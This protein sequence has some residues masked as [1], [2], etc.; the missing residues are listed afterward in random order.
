MVIIF[1]IFIIYGSGQN[2]TNTEIDPTCIGVGAVKP[3]CLKL[4]N[5]P[6]DTPGKSSNRSTGSGILAS[7]SPP[8]VG[9]RKVTLIHG[10]FA[11]G[12]PPEDENGKVNIET[13]C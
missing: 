8:G 13:F 5:S 9:N 12:S 6:S 3:C 10:H 2:V 11:S 1:L 4:R 7:G